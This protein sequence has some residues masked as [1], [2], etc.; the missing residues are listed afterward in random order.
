MKVRIEEELRKKKEQQV[1]EL[2]SII[3]KYNELDNEN[4]EFLAEGTKVKLNY[5]W[6]T[7]EP[8]YINKAKSYKEFVESNK[9]TIFTVEYDK[10]YG[11]KSYMVCLK[12]DMTPTKWLW[13]SSLDLLVVEKEIKD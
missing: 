8:S 9:N 10:K 5:E 11:D 12:E 3:A 13:H 4:N 7:E 1:Q 2:K 6:I